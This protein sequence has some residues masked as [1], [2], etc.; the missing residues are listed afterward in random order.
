MKKRHIALISFPRPSHVNPTLSIV[1]TL[2]RR[3]HRV[4]YTTSAKF[5]SKVRQIGAEYICCPTFDYATL[6]EGAFCH[7]AMSTLAEVTPFYEIYMPDLIIYDIV[8]FAGRLLAHKWH[9]PAVK[10]SPHFSYSEAVLHEQIRDATL[11]DLTISGSRKVDHFLRS[12][13]IRSSGYMF[14][15]EELNIYPFPKDFDPN[16]VTADGSCLYAG[17]CAGEQPYYGDWRDDANDGKPVALVVSSTTYIRGA[18]Y[19]KMCV[20]ALSNLPLNVVL[21]PGGDS[22]IAS[23]LPLPQ[24]VQHVHGTSPAKILSTAS[25]LICTG[26]AMTVSEAMYHGVPLVMTS[27]GIPELEGL[28]EMWVALGLGIHLRAKEMNAESLR[29]AVLNVVGN[30]EILHKVR[31]MQRRVQGEPGSEEV[32]NRIEELIERRSA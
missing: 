2:V 3:G 29:R 20:E 28:C 31:H 23:L 30:P 11:R 9:I 13:G 1:S 18:E 26:G 7:L 16:G 17:R 15:R 5:E 12:H 21:I 4:T 8:A 6:G 19:F 10:V 27:C 24:N 14:H 22:Q 32:A 25:V